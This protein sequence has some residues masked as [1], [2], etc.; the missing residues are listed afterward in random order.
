M[1]ISLLNEK[2]GLIAHMILNLP[3][4]VLISCNNI[5]NIKSGR[6][7][8]IFFLLLA[9]D[10]QGKRSVISFWVE[11]FFFLLVNLTKVHMSLLFEKTCIPDP[12][13]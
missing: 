6:N 9:Y 11:N 5:Y 2:V 7:Q 1:I 3:I 8:L 10:M 12:L 4:H 13:T